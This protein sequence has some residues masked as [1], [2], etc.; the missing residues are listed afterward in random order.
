MGCMLTLCSMSPILNRQQQLP[1][2]RT[3]MARHRRRY[4]TRIRSTECSKRHDL[5]IQ[6][7]WRYCQKFSGR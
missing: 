2:T 5:F 1:L 7:L 6:S 3:I 4:P